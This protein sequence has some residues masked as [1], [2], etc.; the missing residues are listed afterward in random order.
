MFIGIIV[1]FVIVH[2]LIY[3]NKL[4][5]SDNTTLC[6]AVDAATIVAI[7]DLLA[8]TRG[9]WCVILELYIIFYFIFV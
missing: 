8:T 3:S 4:L 1:A 7:T 9:L 5:F 2:C 6:V